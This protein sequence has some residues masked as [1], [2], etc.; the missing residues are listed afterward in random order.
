MIACL[1][2]FF[3]LYTLSSAHASDFDTN[4]FCIRFQYECFASNFSTNVLR[5]TPVQMFCA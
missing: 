5:P 4:V 3:I 1:L 2:F